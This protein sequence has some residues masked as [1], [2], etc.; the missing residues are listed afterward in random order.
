MA[1]EEV[2][3]ADTTAAVDK[4]LLGFLNGICKRQFFG[5]EDITD[6]FLR[7]EVLGGMAEEGM[8][9]ETNTTHVTPSSISLYLVRVRG[10]VEALLVHN[11]QFGINRYGF[12]PAIGIPSVPDEEKT[13]GPI[14]SVTI[15]RNT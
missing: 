10:S 3:M 6:Q 14:Y 7:E 1:R 11:K 15:N 13:G 12:Q 8:E 2:K 4:A 9:E 5:E